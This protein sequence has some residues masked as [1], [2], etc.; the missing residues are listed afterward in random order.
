[1]VN[2][3]CGLIMK[4]IYWKND[5]IRNDVIFH[6]VTRCSMATIFSMGIYCLD[7]DFYHSFVVDTIESILLLLM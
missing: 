3:Y 1:M 4:L 5:V 7:F 2:L 6:D